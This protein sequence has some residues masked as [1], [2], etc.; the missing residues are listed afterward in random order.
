M[1]IMDAD[2]E[3]F[4]RSA[5]S[6]TQTAGRAARN[7]GGRVIMYADRITDSMRLAI[8]DANRRREKQIRYNNLHGIVPR[9]AIKSGR[10]I[11]SGDELRHGSARYDL[12]GAK[13]G[14]AADPVAAYMTDRDIESGDQDRPRGDGE[15]GPGTGLHGRGRLPRPDVRAAGKTK[16]HAEKMTLTRTLTRLIDLLYVKPLR[17]IVPP[18][19]FRYAACGGLN[20]ALDLSLYFLLYNFVLDKRVVH[21]DG[22]VAISPYIAAFLIVFPITFL[23]GFWMNRHIAFHSSPLRGRV[24]LFRYLLSVCG[25]ILLNYACLKLFVEVCGFYPTPSK[26]VTTAVTIV[27]SYVMQ[28]YFSFRGCTDR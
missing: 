27:Y 12:P 22:I 6:L 2:K 1:A 15:R 9:Q 5:R 18:Q 28:K 10:A 24:Q 25:S 17:R 8:Q 13:T 26:A 11:L 4:L 14:C 23:T 19:T 20:M 7:V 16:K 3:G 21:V